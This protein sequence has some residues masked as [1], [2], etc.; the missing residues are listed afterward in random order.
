MEKIEAIRKLGLATSLRP[1]FLQ[2]TA[3]FFKDE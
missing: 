3:E 1:D 2:K